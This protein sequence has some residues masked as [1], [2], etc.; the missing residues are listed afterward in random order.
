MYYRLFLLIIY[1]LWA[2]ALPGYAAAERT[3]SSV[4]HVLSINGAISPAYADYLKHGIAR[5]EK[6]GAALVIVELNTPGGLLSSTRAMVS[7][8]ITADV[9]VAVYVT[10]SG[11][12]AASAGTFLL[13][14]AHIAAMDQG[15]NVGAATP[16]QL[17]TAQLGAGAA[18]PTAPDFEKAIKDL[19]QGLQQDSNT[20]NLQRKAL[21]DTTAFIRAIAEM[22]GRNA[23]WAEKAVTEADSLTAKEALAHGVIDLVAVSRSDLLDKINGKT[24]FLKDR[25]SV[26]LDL[27]LDHPQIVLLPPD[28]LTLFL[29]FISD[30]NVAAILMMMGIYGLILE[31]YIPGNFVAGTIGLLSL[32]LAFYAFSILPVTGLGGLLIASALVFMVAETFIPSFGILGITGIIAMTFGF[33]LLF[34]GSELWGIGLEWQVILGIIVSAAL[35]MGLAFALFVRSVIKKELSTGP[36]AMI[37]KE[38]K[39]LDWTEHSGFVQILGERWQAF[40]PDSEEVFASGDTVLISAV[41]DLRLKVRKMDD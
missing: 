16:V 40:S 35:F 13:M 14:A 6:E 38:A 12:H 11:A 15:T 1:F 32:L 26:T 41:E 20:Q 9:P 23:D 28:I 18:A 8:I 30:P 27:D 19:L 39:V 37:G 25:Q 31:F 4:V 36:E 5:A 22:R 10:P 7:E 3:D 29:A 33:M 2:V 34:D 24:V 17:K 21:E